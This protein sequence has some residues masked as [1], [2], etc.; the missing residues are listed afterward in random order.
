[1]G[2]KS[3]KNQKKED[4]F[5]IKGALKAG[6][7]EPESLTPKQLNIMENLSRF[8][9]DLEFNPLELYK[10]W[11]LLRYQENFPSGIL[12]ISHITRELLDSLCKFEAIDLST[13]ETIIVD[14]EIDEFIVAEVIKDKFKINRASREMSWIGPMQET[15]RN[16]L[17]D[18]S[19]KQDYKFCIWELFKKCSDRREGEMGR[20]FRALLNRMDPQNSDQRDTKRIESEFIN[21]RRYF[22]GLSHVRKEHYYQDSEFDDNIFRVEEILELITK[23]HMSIFEDIDELLS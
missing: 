17:I 21:L 4:P 13:N 18:L 20:K 10:A 9:T 11:L 23:D 5:S 19:E 12:L 22:S 15:E 7:E 2:I 16:Y 6:Q 8:A 14:S 3:S 1:M